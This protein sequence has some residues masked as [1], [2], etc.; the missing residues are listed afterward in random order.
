MWRIATVILALKHA[1]TGSVLGSIYTAHVQEQLTA[2][3]ATSVIV[4]T[5]CLHLSLERAALL[6][7]IVDGKL[8][9]ITPRPMQHM[10]SAKHYSHSMMT[11]S[12]FLKTPMGIT[13]RLDFRISVSGR[14]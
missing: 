10:E 4:G 13:V 1:R 9:V 7:M 5:V 11:R 6:T 3:T 14:D 2:T 8:S 12:L